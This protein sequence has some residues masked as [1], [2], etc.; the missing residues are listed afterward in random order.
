MFCLLGTP[1]TEQAHLDLAVAINTCTKKAGCI[2][3]RSYRSAQRGSGCPIP[4]DSRGQA[5]RGSEQL[6]EL[7][8]SLFSAGGWTGCP[9]KVTSNS[10]N[11]MTLLF[12]NY[13]SVIVICN[14]DCKSHSSGFA[15][16]VD[17]YIFL[18]EKRQ[19]RVSNSLL[20]LSPALSRGV[21]ASHLCKLKAFSKEV[22]DESCDHIRGDCE[23]K[24]HTGFKAASKGHCGEHGQL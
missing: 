2:F 16:S 3:C 10:N 6:M 13:L 12:V 8:V 22:S 11:I 1:S 24:C 4:A 19:N 21:P 20:H 7:W 15:T 17:D 5:G 9:V 14:C 18:N 23:L